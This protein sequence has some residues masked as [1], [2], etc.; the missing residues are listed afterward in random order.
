MTGRAAALPLLLS[1]RWL[2]RVPGG[3]L[4]FRRVCA[5]GRARAPAR[6]RRA[7]AGVHRQRRRKKAALPSR[8]S[9]TPHPAEAVPLA[10]PAAGRAP[11]RHGH[12][13]LCR[14]P[15]H[16]R[17]RAPG[18]QLPA[19]TASSTSGRTNRGIILPPLPARYTRAW[20]AVGGGAGAAAAAAARGGGGQVGRSWGLE[21]SMCCYFEGRRLLIPPRSE[22][23]SEPP[24][25]VSSDPCHP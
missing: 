8:T 12:A 2:A 5:P 22:Q 9:R 25:T 3:L 13:P 23:G 24:H 21:V 7:A 18:T 4:E 16:L 19:R 1:T 14:H 20:A 15:I 6:H 10:A 11:R 17:P